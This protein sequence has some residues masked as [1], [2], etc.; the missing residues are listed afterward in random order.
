[1]GGCVSLQQ[2][3][4]RKEDAMH[5][6]KQRSIIQERGPRTFQGG[7]NSKAEDVSSAGVLQ[8]IQSILEQDDRRSL[9]GGDSLLIVWII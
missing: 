3:K 9:E 4:I 8:S 5:S 6:R 2:A 7:R 1:M